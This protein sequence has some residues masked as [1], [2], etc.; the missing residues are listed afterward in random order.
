MDNSFTFQGDNTST[1]N[2]SC[3]FNNNQKLLKVPED[4]CLVYR[5]K[6]LNPDDSNHAIINYYQYGILDRQAELKTKAFAQTFN[7]KAFDYLRTANQLGYVVIAQPII[8]N[9]V[10]GLA[11]FIQGSK[12]SPFEM[13]GLIEDF[14]RYFEDYLYNMDENNMKQELENIDYDVFERRNKGFFDKSD[15]YWSEIYEGDYNFDK[16]DVKEMLKGL[17]KLDIMQFYLDLMKNKQRKL[18]IQVYGGNETITND[19][20]STDRNYAGKGE[21]LVDGFNGLDLISI[22]DNK[23]KFY[24]QS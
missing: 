3:S 24:K 13:D 19:T 7:L 2:L 21:R 5:T 14:L 12:K 10:L 18:S 22:V 1:L 6:N 17:R 15:A 23:L 8:L 4:V 16:K 11:V 20:V 9:K